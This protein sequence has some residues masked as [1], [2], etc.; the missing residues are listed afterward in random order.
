MA[1]LIDI[2]STDV[3]T[4]VID[5]LGELF[6]GVPITADKL[7]IVDSYVTNQAY[8]FVVTGQPENS[9]T[10][11]CHSIFSNAPVDVIVYE[12]VDCAEPG[13]LNAIDKMLSGRAKEL[14]GRG[15]K[16]I[17]QKA[18]RESSNRLL[19]VEDSFRAIAITLSIDYAYCI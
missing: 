13:V 15:V 7:P 18:R 4:L 16:I 9:V 2:G 6:P 14:E 12:R 3:V 17:I 5:W 1:G 10:Q 19:M 11:S 8:S